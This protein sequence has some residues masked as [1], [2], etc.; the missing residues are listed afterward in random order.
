M[1]SPGEVNQAVG[2]AYVE[3]F[4]ASLQRTIPGF[5]NK[6]LVYN[7]PEKTAFDGRASKGYSFDFN[8]VFRREGRAVDVFGESKGYSNAGNLMD[9]Y[10][11]FLAKA[12][13][14]STDYKRNR[15]DHFWFVT[16]VPFACS[17]GSGVRNL[18]FARTTLIEKRNASVK[19]ILGDSHVDEGF[20]RD[21][22][23]RLGVFILTDSYLM[24]SMLAYRV[25]RG[26]T[27]WSILKNL[28]GGR[29]PAG[30]GSLAGKIARINNLDSPDRI[31]SGQRINLK[32]KG[33]SG[34]E[35]GQSF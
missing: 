2:K 17:E 34:R 14:T 13:V 32:W 9:E 5:E 3:V 25:K 20:L 22:I 27:L 21:L 18:A 29:A 7:E 16:N 28:N 10:R 31:R 1:A 6:F 30:F 19:E 15:E 33:I 8:G 4:V 23:D 26:D 12:Y 35:G 24:N 11:A